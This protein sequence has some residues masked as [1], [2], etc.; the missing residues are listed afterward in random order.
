MFEPT[1]E[2]A[3][4]P[5]ARIPVEPASIA[6]GGRLHLEPAP[7]HR[8]EYL[9]APAEPRSLSGNRGTVRRI[10][11]GSWRSDGRRITLR[12]DAGEDRIW[13]V[14]ASPVPLTLERIA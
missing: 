5:S 8:R 4:L 6:L 9:D 12:Q 3:P 14:V 11:S 7:N 13:L 2:D 10:A 1:Q